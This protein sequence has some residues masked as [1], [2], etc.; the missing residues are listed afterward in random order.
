MKKI[1]Y[2]ILISALA[3]TFGTVSVAADLDG[4]ALFKKKCSKCHNKTKKKKIGPG[5]K[6]VKDRAPR[7]WA[8]K[9]VG[10]PQG[11]W[12]KNE[13][14]TATMRKKLKGGEKRKKTKMKYKTMK[15]VPPTPEETEAILDYAYT[16]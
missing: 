15:V 5:M 14:Y 10:D 2:G 16:L 8:S 3:I 4:K 7:D 1:F 9:W 13:G 6:G 11:M 12:T